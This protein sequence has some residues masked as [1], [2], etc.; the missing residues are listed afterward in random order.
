M[1]A[2]MINSIYMGHSTHILLEIS[3]IKCFFFYCLINSIFYVDQPVF[4][5]RYSTNRKLEFECQKYMRNQENKLNNL[6][7][8]VTEKEDSNVNI[9]AKILEQ[10]EKLFETLFKSF[11]EAKNTKSIVPNTDLKIAETLEKLSVD[12]FQCLQ[13]QILIQNS[14]KLDATLPTKNRGYPHEDKFEKIENPKL[15]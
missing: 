13:C 4:D 7:K 14:Q 5:R 10:S 3:K 11:I 15:V 12:I 1:N 6:N 2:E 9:F 8:N